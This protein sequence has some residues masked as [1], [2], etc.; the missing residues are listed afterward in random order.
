MSHPLVPRL[1]TN[2]HGLSW[3]PSSNPYHYKAFR[4]KVNQVG[5]YPTSWIL[6]KLL[7]SD[8][9]AKPSPRIA[10]SL[11]VPKTA[12]GR[13]AQYF[14]EKLD[15][16]SLGFLHVWPLHLFS[17]LHIFF[18]FIPSFL[19]FFLFLFSPFSFSFHFLLIFS[20]PLV[21]FSPF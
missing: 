12:D 19:L 10:V 3:P 1:G 18:S 17:S 11:L 20:S 9:H 4:L 14:R 15:V 21:I 8:T 7:Q 16:L 13:I 6:W 2:L 5:K